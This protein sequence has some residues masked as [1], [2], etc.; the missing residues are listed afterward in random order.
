LL[1]MSY[2]SDPSSL[3]GGV[4]HVGTVFSF[5]L[6]LRD[7]YLHNLSRVGGLL[8]PRLIDFPVFFDR[9]HEIVHV[10]EDLLEYYESICRLKLPF[11]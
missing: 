5:H 9:S 3:P 8:L 11:H 2:I 7:L 4:D 10:I 6:L 1:F